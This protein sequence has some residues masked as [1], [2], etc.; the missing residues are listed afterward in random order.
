MNERPPRWHA[1]FLVHAE[2]LAG[3]FSATMVDISAQGGRLLGIPLDTLAVG[4]RLDLFAA[5]LGMGAEVRWVRFDTCGLLFDRD[6]TLRELDLAR[7]T[8]QRGKHRM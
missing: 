5:G 4:D 7:R 8:A 3:R 2:G 1:R 6:L